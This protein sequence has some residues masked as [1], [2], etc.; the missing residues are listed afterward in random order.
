MGIR[1]VDCIPNI[2]VAYKIEHVYMV[3][4]GAAMHLNDALGNHSELRVHYLHHEQ[5]CSIAAESNARHHYIPSVV[6]VTA[7][8]GSI[9]AINGVFGAYVDS[10]PMIVISGQAKTSTLVNSYCDDELRQLGDQEVDICNAMKKMT[11]Y[12]KQLRKPEDIKYELEKCI[13]LSMNGRPGPCWLDIPI[14]IQGAIVNQKELIGFKNKSENSFSKSNLKNNLPLL[15]QKIKQAK[16]P[17]IYAGSGIRASKS[18]VKLINF[19]EELDIPIVTSWNS[20]DLIWDDHKL[21]AGRPGTVGTR[22][23]N[24]VVQTCDVLLVLGARLNIRQISYNWECFADQAW[25]C[26]IDVDESELNKPTLSQDLKINCDLKDFFNLIKLN[27]L[28]NCL[29]ETQ[30]S[31]LKWILWISNLKKKFNFYYDQGKEASPKDKVNPY[32]FIYSLTKNLKEKDNIVFADGTA[33]VAGFQSAVIKKGQRL[34]HNSGC[35]SMGYE[36]PAA[37]GAYHATKNKI[38]C[39]AGDGSIMM[40]IQDLATISLEALP[41]VIFILENQGYHS[42]RQTQ[43]NF[44]SGR[45]VGCGNNSGLNFPDFHALGK[46]FKIETIQVNNNSELESAI[47]KSLKTNSPLLVVL[48]IDKSIPFTPK[49][50]SKRLEDGTMITARLEDMSPFLPREIHNKILNSVHDIE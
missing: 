16:R 43:E 49:V 36:L 25:I 45:S 35:A 10:I 21:F 1:V 44:F 41:I 6:N 5:S 12:T 7:G 24:Y 33:C 39:V 32:F 13:Y 23:G 2:L 26:Q 47:K 42:I 15:I 29:K 19:A 18:C 28:K 20:N 48:K 22:V 9:N 11:K 27:D 8:P 4:G 17:L 34:Y 3:T 37:I 46:G 31:R 30:K 38:Y 50:S 40:N 14:D